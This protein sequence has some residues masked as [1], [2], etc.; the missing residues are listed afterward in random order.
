MFFKAV[1]QRDVDQIERIVTNYSA[2]IGEFDLNSAED[3]IG[4]RALHFAAWFNR[5]N[6]ARKL[7]AKG[8]DAMAR[9]KAN[10]TAL[11]WAALSGAPEI[12]DLLLRQVINGR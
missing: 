7:L 12:V 5:P 4:N 8:A 1:E 2:E 10:E 3:V 9:N 6:L 11:H